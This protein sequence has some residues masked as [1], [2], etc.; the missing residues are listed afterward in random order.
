MITHTWALSRLR[1]SP[2]LPALVAVVFLTSACGGAARQAARSAEAGD[3]DTAVEYYQRALQDDPD[4]PEYRIALERAML[5]ASQAHLAAG[6]A[7][8]AQQELSV[9]LREYL[10]AAEYDPSNTQVSAHAALLERTIRDQIEAARPPAPI[11]ALRAQARLETAPPL[12]DPASRD[13]LTFDFRQTSLQ[14]LLDFIGDATSIN[15]TYDEQFQ[16]RQ[17]TLR[18]DGMT[19]EATLDHILMTNQ[20]FYKVLNA[21]TI[22]IVPENLQKRA[23]YDEQVIQ[24]FYV[25]HADVQEL[26]QLL[27]Q[28]VRVPQMAV[29]PS[30]IPNTVSNTITVR[31]TTAVSAII[32]QVISANDKPPAEI[33]IDVEILEV[34]RERARRYG[35]NLTDYSLG[36]VFSPE[37]A[38]SN[39][40][41]TPSGIS[42]SPPFNVNTVSRGVSTA[43]FYLGVPAAV[44]R[45]LETDSQTKLVAKPQLRGQEGQTMTLN[46][47]DD[48]PVPATAFTPIAAGGVA[49]NPLTSF[50]YRPVG[51]I[52]EMTPR[53][54]YENEVIL[55]LVVE[56]ST[57]GAN[58]DV[59]GTSLPTF[60][61]RRVVTRLR[62][63]DGESNLLAGLLRE[64]D[65]QELR[66]F[67][68]TLGV[69]LLRSLFG[70]TDTA[71]RQTDIIM[72]L[73]PRIIRT[74][75]LTQRDV[76][77]IHIGTQTN[78]ALTGP[79][80]LIAP[81]PDAGGP[82]T[83]ESD[84]DGDDTALDAPVPDTLD[85]DA[86]PLIAELEPA[87]EPE[88]APD[89]E[90]TPEP[91]PDPEPEPEP[92]DTTPPAPVEPE[93]VVPPPGVEPQ[94]PAGGPDGLAGI[95]VLITPPGSEFRVGG[96]PYTVPVSLNG[97][98]QL[99]AIT[100]TLFYDPNILSVRT[101]QE[102][103]FL[104]QGGTQVAFT[105]QVDTIVGRID[106]TATRTDDA[107][108][109]S[110]AGL[111]AAVLFDAVGPGS[112]TLSASGTAV[113]PGGAP[114]ALLFT[115]VTVVA[116]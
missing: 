26:S 64:E 114:L 116:E 89:P 39:E 37:V 82:D 3:W 58:I 6:R 1:R 32:E 40:A 100:L 33:V 50:N 79:P 80:A 69:P 90:P 81:R 77:P 43:D 71:V 52:I 86:A 35:L 84:A 14:D 97:A 108:G 13:P 30:V 88:S 18:I 53:V 75:E 22:I 63:R 102:G 57:L 94:I 36:S 55:E 21:R 29:Q 56:N 5:S 23:Q 66:G 83:L 4:R 93:P 60:G 104:R 62:L 76:S 9:A 41:I 107:T 85:A 87:P 74:H 113:T 70:D 78:F 31:A 61:S 98:S 28:I 92:D 72:L 51:V 15:V 59:A 54:T 27:S 42:S 10:A 112:A 91:E 65:R 12:L 109:A 115:P 95:Q 105:Q 45:F 99:S 8:E 49:V 103:S 110:G 20:L 73:T 96:G 48:I 44:V 68:G 47:G 2:Y 11:E 34:N 7:F 25:S 46:L 19:L 106:M 101:V 24:T 111:L 16:D 67:P 17:V 38:P